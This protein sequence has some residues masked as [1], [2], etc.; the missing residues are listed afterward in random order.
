MW[1][2][3]YHLVSECKKMFESIEIYRQLTE[4]Y[5]DSIMNKASVRKWCIMFK[6]GWS[7]VHDEKHSGWPSLITETLKKKVDNK[8]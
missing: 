8:I 4:V 6:E 5:G 3:E 7:N 2:S 1:S